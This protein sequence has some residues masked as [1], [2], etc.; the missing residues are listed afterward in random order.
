MILI[1][2]DYR[3]KNVHCYMIYKY[4]NNSIITVEN[5]SKIGNLHI[6]LGVC[7]SFYKVYAYIKI[8]HKLQL[9]LSKFT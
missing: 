1:H 2:F 7:P 5:D 8:R 3:R 6:I 4:N 9:W